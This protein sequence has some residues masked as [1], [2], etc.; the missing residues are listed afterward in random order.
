MPARTR[1]VERVAI[2]TS[3]SLIVWLLHVLYG[4]WLNS[5]QGVLRVI[6]LLSIWSSVMAVWGRS[7]R[8]D[9]A[10]ALWLG[11]F[12]ASAALLFSIGPGNIWPIALATAAVLSAGAVLAGIVLG[13]AASV[14]R[15]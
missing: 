11:A 15:H 5:G 1:F 9:L 4:W 6:V 10:A 13:V 8:W 14:F 3:G 12:V 2:F 7:R